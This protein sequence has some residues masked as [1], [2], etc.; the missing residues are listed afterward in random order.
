M[1]KE[2]N[3]SEEFKKDVTEPRKPNYLSIT[4]ALV[5]IVLIFGTVGAA[6]YQLSTNKVDQN[7]KSNEEK[8]ES[9]PTIQEE[10]T[11]SA[12]NE[13]SQPEPQQP[14]DPK[15][16]TY[17]VVEGDN[18]GAIAAKYSTTAEKLMADNGITD[19]TAL[20]IG[21]VLKIIK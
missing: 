12:R 14:V 1:S 11:G 20:Q 3:L 2:N 19:E 8:I 9:Q 15:E 5:A 4:L 13:A 17:T 16:E 7:L 21:Q 6:I 10:S 18:L